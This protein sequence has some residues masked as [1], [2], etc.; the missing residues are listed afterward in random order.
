M[1]PTRRGFT[2][3]ELLVVIAIIAI[4]IGL[5]LPAVQKVREAAARTQCANNMKQLG[6]AAHNYHDVHGRLPHHRRCPAPFA[7]GADP[8]CW[9]APDPFQWTG[10]D[11][12]FWVAFDNRPGTTLYDRLPDYRPDGFLWPFLESNQKVLLCP[13]GVEDETGDPDLGREFQIAYALNGVTRGPEGKALV[14]VSNGSGTSNVYYAWEHNN[15]PICFVGPGGD[16]LPIPRGVDG[17]ARHYPERHMGMI[18]VAYCDGHVEPA[19]PA[20]LAE[21]RFNAD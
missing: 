20:E 14:W 9:T 4:L 2:L 17:S 19:R 6:L 15:G 5:L 3:I 21:D 7:G 11:E 1:G 12:R 10:P 13:K 16:R 8:L 18:L